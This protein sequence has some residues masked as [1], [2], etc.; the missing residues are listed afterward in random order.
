MVDFG[1]YLLNETLAQKNVTWDFIRIGGT[2]TNAL[3]GYKATWTMTD[4]KH[5]HLKYFVTL[6]IN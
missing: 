5:I 3:L 6:L 1:N 4:G 2:T